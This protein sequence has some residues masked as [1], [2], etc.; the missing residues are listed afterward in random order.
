MGNLQ[1]VGNSQVLHVTTIKQHSTT[2]VVH[3][4]VKQPEPKQPEIASDEVAITTPRGVAKKLVGGGL[5]GS[6]IIM[7][8]ESAIKS[9][10]YNQLKGP[11]LLGIGTG[12]AFGAGIGLANVHTGDPTL[13]MAKNTAAGA[14]IGGAV[15]S[16]GS[17]IVRSIAT[18]SLLGGSAVGI[19]AGAAIG[20]SI[21]LLNSQD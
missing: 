11:S 17:A 16:V 13:D 7:V 18:E 12:L 21:G 14:L 15:G 4:E 5:L 1:T 10:G 3:T 2:E 9:I 8:G 6:G 19:I 20:A